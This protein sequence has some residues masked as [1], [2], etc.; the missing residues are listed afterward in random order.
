MDLF[1]AQ[2]AIGLGVLV[3]TTSTYF[4]GRLTARRDAMKGR[5]GWIAVVDRGV[6][7]YEPTGTYRAR[8]RAEQQRRSLEAGGEKSF[9]VTVPGFEALVLD[10]VGS[11]ATWGRIDEV[12]KWIE[13]INARLKPKPAADV[14]TTILPAVADPGPGAERID[15]IA[16]Q[17]AA[18]SVRVGSTEEM[19]REA[20]ELMDAFRDSIVALEAT[21]R[22][23]NDKIGHTTAEMRAIAEDVERNV[24]D[25]VTKEF[26]VPSGR[27]MVRTP[28]GLAAIGRDMENRRENLPDGKKE[29]EG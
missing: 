16:S 19:V 28:S 10:W 3:S 6:F 8:A 7:G 17:I 21:M 25:P 14:E 1:S 2:G 20:A 11:P 9:V 24:Q 27:I 22:E 26:P 18:L 29:L 4:L 5:S 13:E 23:H 15:G 12:E